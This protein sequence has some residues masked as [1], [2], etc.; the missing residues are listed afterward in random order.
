MISAVFALALSAHLS[1]ALCIERSDDARA[2][3]KSVLLSTCPSKFNTS[4]L[5]A[6]HLAS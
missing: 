5:R 2:D 1:L 6:E 4:L 3:L